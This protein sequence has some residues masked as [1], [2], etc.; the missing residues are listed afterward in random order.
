MKSNMMNNALV[1]HH[2]N[3]GSLLLCFSDEKGDKLWNM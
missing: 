2:D 3:N 1:D